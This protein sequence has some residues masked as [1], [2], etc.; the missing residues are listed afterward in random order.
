MVVI[1][2][3]PMALSKW[4]NSASAVVKVAVLVMLGVMGLA[5]ALKNGGRQLVR[6]EGWVPSF[7]ANWSF[8]PIIIYNFMGFELMSSRREPSK[9]P[10]PRYSAHA[11]FAGAIIVGAQLLG[12][13]GILAAVPLGD[14]LYRPG[15]GRR[16]EADLRLG[17][18]QRR[19][20]RLRLFV[21][22]LV[23]FTAIIIGDGGNRVRCG[24][25]A[26][27]CA[28]RRGPAR[29]GRRL[30]EGT[31]V[32]NEH[33]PRLTDSAFVSSRSWRRGAV[34][35]RSSLRPRSDDRDDGHDVPLI[36]PAHHRVGRKYVDLP[37]AVPR[38]RL[39]RRPAG[40]RDEAPRRHIIAD[41]HAPGPGV[42]GTCSG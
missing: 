28:R 34:S 3:L 6:A 18:R 12:N 39:F 14:H 17:A 32:R 25:Q 13:F 8:L 30:K 31:H 10:P 33:P 1:G 40:L 21:G 7:G 22:A 9:E 16:H 23:I 2:I 36:F 5:F 38:V 19:H 11:V 29:T 42:P 26:V 15:H 41:D 35:R 37:P 4:V 20:G 27:A 24:A